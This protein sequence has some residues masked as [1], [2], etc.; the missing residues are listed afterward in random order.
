MVVELMKSKL[1]VYNDEAQV[2]V[3]I[4]TA[5]EMFERRSWWNDLDIAAYELRRTE[6]RDLTGRTWPRVDMPYRKHEVVIPT[7]KS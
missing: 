4:V 2:R 6:Y 3:D 7:N 1:Q 5:L